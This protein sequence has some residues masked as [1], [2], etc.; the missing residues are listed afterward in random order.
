[1]ATETKERG[2]T[3]DGSM[4]MTAPAGCGFADEPVMAIRVHLVCIAC[5]A[6]MQCVGAAPALMMSSGGAQQRPDFIHQCQTCQAT[7]R[8][9]QP[10]P[11]IRYE[12][13]PD[14]QVLP[15]TTDTTDLA[16]EASPREDSSRGEQ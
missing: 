3:P 11:T 8:M 4:V 12:T 10:W 1:M 6:P 16:P 9:K 13:H 2:D 7:V 5:E 15:D 14:Y